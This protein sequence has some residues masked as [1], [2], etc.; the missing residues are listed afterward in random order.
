[1]TEGF[2]GELRGSVER[3]DVEILTAFVAGEPAGVALISYPLNFS[4]SGRFASLDELYVP[5][6]HRGSG[7]GSALLE[8]IE[9]RCRDRDVSYVEVQVEDDSAAA[10][11]RAVGFE[12]ESGTRIFSRSYTLR[13]GKSR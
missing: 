11:Y 13:E 5:E 2:T 10:F 12:V 8:T 6:R 3:G 9:D 7:I 1:M 4:V